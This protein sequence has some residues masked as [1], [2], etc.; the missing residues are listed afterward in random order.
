M[1][2]ARAALSFVLGGGIVKIAHSR[3]VSELDDQAA[4]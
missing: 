2:S 3:L 1:S 4:C